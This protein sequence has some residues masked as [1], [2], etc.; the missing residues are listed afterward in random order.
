MEP[1]GLLKCS[2]QSPTGPYAELDQTSPY[3]AIPSL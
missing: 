3:H 1:E 2:Q